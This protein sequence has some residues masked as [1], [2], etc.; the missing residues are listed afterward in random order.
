MQRIDTRLKKGD[1][2]GAIGDYDEL[3]KWRSSDTAVVRSL[4]YDGRGEL[5]E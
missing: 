4:Y 3:I 2:D 5:E 1:L